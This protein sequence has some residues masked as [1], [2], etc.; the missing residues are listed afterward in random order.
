MC[1]RQRE[2]SG[3]DPS[4]SLPMNPAPRSAQKPAAR[5]RPSGE[6]PGPFLSSVSSS[7]RPLDTVPLAP[8]FLPRTASLSPS[9]SVQS[10]VPGHSRPLGTE[11]REQS[12]LGTSPPAAK[13]GPG[14]PP[15]GR[16]RCAAPFGPSGAR[17]ERA[18]TRAA[19]SFSGLSRTHT[20][21]CGLQWPVPLGCATLPGRVFRLSM[22]TDAL[23]CF[24]FR[25][26]SGFASVL[27]PI[28][29]AQAS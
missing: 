29:T 20:N 1:Y 26:K 16:W 21:V 4:L 23:C 2:R 25:V 18:G 9:L 7:S 17:P 14:A 3:N 11:V 13:R 5:G 28:L 27:K 10:E 24:F 12:S 6:G 15:A 22:L 8:R 19:Q